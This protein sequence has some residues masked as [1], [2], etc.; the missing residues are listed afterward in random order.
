MRLAGFIYF[1]E[2]ERRLLP[3][4]QVIQVLHKIPR[5]K[6]LLT[7]DGE[8]GLRKVM[9]QVNCFEKKNKKTHGSFK[10]TSIY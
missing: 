5:M 2:K 3:V 8:T 4:I 1:I 9:R 6:K 7:F 10:C